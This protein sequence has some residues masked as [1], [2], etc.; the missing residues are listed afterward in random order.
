MQNEDVLEG[1]KDDLVMDVHR[2]EKKTVVESLQRKNLGKEK[3]TL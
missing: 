2:R 3:F 1:L